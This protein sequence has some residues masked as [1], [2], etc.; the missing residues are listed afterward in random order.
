VNEKEI[1][2]VR[3]LYCE[4]RKITNPPASLRL[5]H[6][7]RDPSTGEHCFFVDELGKD[8]IVYVHKR[9]DLSGLTHFRTLDIPKEYRNEDQT[10]NNKSFMA[11]WIR[12][13][14]GHKLIETDIGYLVVEKTKVSIVISADSMR[15]TNSFQL[16][17]L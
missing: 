15:F 9:L 7:R 17:R 2:L 5:T 12:R 11:D 10:L 13:K 16:T 4:E 1:S 8:S 3:Q 6:N 14:T